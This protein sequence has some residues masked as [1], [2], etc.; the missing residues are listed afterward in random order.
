MI[1]IFKCVF[2]QGR[3]KNVSS[4]PLQTLI[5]DC[6]AHEPLYRP[7][8]RELCKD[9]QRHVS[10]ETKGML[11]KRKIH[12]LSLILLLFWKGR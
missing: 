6:W 5:E 1:A 8:F 9:L 3:E 11:L 4:Y 7:E 2:S 10:S 12:N